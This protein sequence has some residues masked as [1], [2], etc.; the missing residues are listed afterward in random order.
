MIAFNQ[1]GK[2]VGKQANAGVLSIP[3]EN[4]FDAYQSGALRTW[5]SPEKKLT[6]G[7]EFILVRTM[8]TA[9]MIGK[10]CDLVKKAIFHGKGV[11]SEL[12][13]ELERVGRYI[14][15]L[16]DFSYV[17]DNEESEIDPMVVEMLRSVIGVFGEAAEY[18]D[19][20]LE[21]EVSGDTPPLDDMELEVGDILYY[22]TMC[23]NAINAKMSDVARGNTEKLQDRWPSGWKVA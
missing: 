22:T 1:S 7:E 3:C 23:A 9:C 17:P 10:C 2:A 21:M 13:D 18:T 19:H 8:S 15:S 12:L 16:L 14:P 4:D 20:V 5:A 6:E 11:D